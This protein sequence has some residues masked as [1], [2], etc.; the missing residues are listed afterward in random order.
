[1]QIRQQKTIM[2]VALVLVVSIYIS[3]L[4]LGLTGGTSDSNIDGGCR[5][6]CHS[7]EGNATVEMWTSNDTVMV[8]ETVA[9]FV[10]VTSWTL[11]SNKMIGV[12]LLKSF[13]DQ[14]ADLPS[15]DGWRILTDPNGNKFNYVEKV[16]GVAGETAS[17]RWDLRAPFS[18]GTYTLYS[19]VHHGGAGS[20]WEVNATGLTFEVL[21]DVS[22]K[23]D[24]VL[25]ATFFAVQPQVGREAIFYATVLN[26]FSDSLDEIG[27]D[28]SIDGNVIGE[29]RNQTI[30]GNGIRNVTVSWSP[31]QKGN[32]TL[33][34][35]VDP[36]DEFGENDESNN[37]LT[38]S[39]DVL[40]EEFHPTPRLE[41]LG[42]L[43]GVLVV[44]VAGVAILGLRKGRKD[45]TA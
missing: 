15:N 30:V 17:F 32:F 13:T 28:F 44:F 18:A 42:F 2:L 20:L 9:V 7:T 23:P 39:F 29:V 3:S 35:V 40:D 38:L 33:T 21:P 12:F 14:P 36:S 41:I 26:D 11:T 37:E 34:V 24:L 10:N 8:D 43:V 4:T 25:I 6:S 16:V 27:V 22:V 1:M 19:R 31:L 5:L 45:E